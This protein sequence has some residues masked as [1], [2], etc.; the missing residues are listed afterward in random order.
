[1][2]TVLV[3]FLVTINNNRTAVYS[4]PLATL[5]DCQR[6]QNSQPMYW[7]NSKQC[8]QVRIVK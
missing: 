7:V 4:P 8:V 3:W 6:L 5:E 1:M 2:T